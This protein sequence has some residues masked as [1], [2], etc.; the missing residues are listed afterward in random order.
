MNEAFKVFL[1]LVLGAII[2]SFFNVLIYRV[3]R[4]MSVISPRSFCP[5]CKTIIPW[6]ANM[7][8]LS[9]LFLKGKC[10]K[11]GA[12]IPLRYLIVEIITPLAY[13]SLFY[14]HNFDL[15]P[16]LGIELLVV[17]IFIVVTFIDLETYLIPDVFS[18]GG[19]L[20]GLFLSP[21][22]KAVTV[23]D[24]ILGVVLGGGILVVISFFYKKLKG[25]E[26]M[27]GGDVK[28]LAMIGA[29]T[30]WKGAIIA[31]FSSALLGTLAGVGLVIIRRIKAGSCSVNLG[32]T[33]IPYGPFLALG[34]V[35]ALF[36][37]NIIWNWYF[38]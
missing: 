12:K 36:G 11:C 33:M 27:G 26:G 2:G 4:K 9:Y 25:V 5:S 38:R 15:N 13:L 24:A 30:G 16:Q 6:W 8:V 10:F 19:L 7:P 14:F 28:F 17:S 3:P 23:S 20:V 21:W 37:G 31:L 29:F 32:T 1:I 18:L 34:G 22:N 35:I